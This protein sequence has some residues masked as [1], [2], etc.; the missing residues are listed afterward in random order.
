MKWRRNDLEI[1]W[2]TGCF[3]LIPPLCYGGNKT[4]SLQ[5]SITM[6]NLVKNPGCL[7]HCLLLY[8]FQFYEECLVDSFFTLHLFKKV[9]YKLSINIFLS[10]LCFI[11]K[12]W[13]LLIIIDYWEHWLKCI[14]YCTHWHGEKNDSLVCIRLTWEKYPLIIMLLFIFC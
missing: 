6:Q 8:K 12:S 11:M 2:Q 10:Q 3:V 14:L 7:W 9:L 1:P 5:L 13:K 4:T